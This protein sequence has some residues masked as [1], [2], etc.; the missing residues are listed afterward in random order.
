MTAYPELYKIFNLQ[1]QINQSYLSSYHRVIIV[2]TTFFH[3][4]EF[5]NFDQLLQSKKTTY[6]KLMKEE[7]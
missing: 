2:R 4:G 7:R 1:Q 3:E 6:G 5:A